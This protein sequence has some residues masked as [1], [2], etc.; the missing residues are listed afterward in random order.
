MVPMIDWQYQVTV[1]MPLGA[2]HDVFRKAHLGEKSPL[3]SD[4]KPA[5]KKRMIWVNK[6]FFQSNPEGNSPDK[7][8]ADAMG[9]LSLVV[10]YAKNAQA[11]SEPEKSPKMLTTIMPRTDFATIYGDV[12]SD[13]KGDLYNLVSVMLCYK[14]GADDEVE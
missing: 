13:I 10:S 5:S 1:P 4:F 8:T 11:R 14:N 2:I 12:K 9:F 7:I 6:N 3:L